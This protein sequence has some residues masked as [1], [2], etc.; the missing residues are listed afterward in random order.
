MDN[1]HAIST[2]IPKKTRMDTFTHQERMVSAIN[3]DLVPSSLVC[4]HG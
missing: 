1:D 3:C 2:K 4:L